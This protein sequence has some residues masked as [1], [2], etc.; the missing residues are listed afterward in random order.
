MGLIDRLRGWLGLPGGD[1]I[2]DEDEADDGT[3]S[4]RLDPDDVTEVRT[5][6]ED[7][8]V[9]RLRELERDGDDNDD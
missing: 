6:R 9:E 1:E 5:E 8:P 4:P 7:D 2:D 3:G